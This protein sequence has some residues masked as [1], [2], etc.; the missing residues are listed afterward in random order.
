MTKEL[1]LNANATLRNFFMSD[2]N[3][4]QA[5]IE[6]RVIAPVERFELAYEVERIAPKLAVYYTRYVD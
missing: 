5:L 4:H 6:L 3:V 1:I 2:M